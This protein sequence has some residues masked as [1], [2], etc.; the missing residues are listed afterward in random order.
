M[1][2]QPPARIKVDDGYVLRLL[3][4]SDADAVARSV[5]E[6]LEHLQPWMPW[7]GEE[8]T[9]ESFQRTRLRGAKHKAAKGEEWQYGLFPRG[10]ASLVGSFGMM[11]GKWP[12]T[13]EI[14]YWVHV[15]ETGRGLARRATRA[16][17][18]VALT[19]D[20]IATVCIRCDEAN[21]RSASVPRALGYTLIRT[22]TR[23]PE[24]PAESGRLMVWE[25]TEPIA[26]ALGQAEI[27]R[28]GPSTEFARVLEGRRSEPQS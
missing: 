5:R 26:E 1:T 24:A 15:A 25:R 23:D 8:S 9:K 2:H 11:G 22:E 21:V 7:A 12:A 28:P 13:I 16:L 17:T 4:I 19:L 20:G 27:P 10:E 14:G 3:G 6:S 18:N